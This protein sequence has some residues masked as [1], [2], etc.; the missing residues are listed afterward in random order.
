[1]MYQANPVNQIQSTPV[2]G[3]KMM[4][5]PAGDHIP[6]ANTEDNLGMISRYIK[7][8]TSGTYILGSVNGSIQWIG[9]QDCE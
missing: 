1:M 5:L 7:P 8:P 3:V 4:K 2:I 6:I 9:T